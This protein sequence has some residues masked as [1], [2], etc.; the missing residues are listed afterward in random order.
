MAPSGTIV[1]YAVLVAP[2]F[3]AVMTA[4]S[5]AAVERDYSQFMLLAWSL[6]ASLLIDVMFIGMYQVAEGNITDF[7]QLPGVLFDPYL[8]VD[9]I[10]YMLVF[11]VIVG[12]V[13]AIGI[14]LDL[15]GRTRRRLQAYAQIKFDPRQPW[16]NFMEETGSVRVKTSD[17]QL[18]AGDVV[19]WS[20]AERSRQLR[21]EDPRWYNPHIHDYVDVGREDMLFFEE[22]ISRLLMRT[23]YDRPGLWERVMDRVSSSSESTA[24][25]SSEV[26]ENSGDKTESDE[27]E[28]SS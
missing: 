4:N 5:L 8:R 10:A 15:P 21:I 7:N 12:I 26:D 27:D 16:P 14:L 3:L 19:E 20:R 24:E 13:A 2:G 23:R 18:Y 1:F 17:N 6:V 9:Y 25:Q 28:E 11:S 22:D